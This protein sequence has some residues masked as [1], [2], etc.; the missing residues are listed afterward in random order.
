MTHELNEMQLMMLDMMKWFHSFCQENNIKYF[1][2]GGTML[3]AVRHQG[4]IP[5]DDDIDVGI[6]RKDYERLIREK[7]SLFGGEKRYIFESY[8]DGK[9]DFIYAYA[10]IYDTHTTLVEN[11]R[12]HAKRGIF[13]DVFPLDGIGS[14]REDA[15]KNFLPIKRRVNFLMTRTCELRKSRKLVKNIAIVL[16][17]LLPGF[18]FDNH[19]FIAKINYLCSERDFESSVFV[20]NLF[21]NWGKKEI[22]PKSYFGKPTLYKFEDMYV[23][24]PEDYDN[25]LRNVYNNWCQLPPIEEQK[26]HHDFL[27]MDLHQHYL[28]L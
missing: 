14:S 8:H 10:K 9:R 24:G 7:K 22:M 4:F 23:Y 28:E 17:R 13:I 6:P 19:K 3:G 1:V 16:S 21:G 2:I 18:L 15:Y 12:H 26:S 20:G 27:F 25:Y 5:W 11:C